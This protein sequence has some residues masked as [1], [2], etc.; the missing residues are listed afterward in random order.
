MEALLK[1]QKDPRMF[2][3]GA[4]F[5]TY[6]FSEPRAWNYYER[7]MSGEF[8]IKSTGWVTPGDEEKKPLD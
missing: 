1:E 7:Y 6:P 3:K 2:G 8:S 5:N 4:I